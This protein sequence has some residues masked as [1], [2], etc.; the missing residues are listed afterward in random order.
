MTPIFQAT[1]D[2]GKKIDNS[3]ADQKTKEL[4]AHWDAQVMQLGNVALQA[5]DIAAM[6]KDIIL[7]K[8]TSFRVQANGDPLVTEIIAAKLKDVAS[9]ESIEKMAKH[10]SDAL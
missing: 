7:G 4:M 5:S 2:S 1:V 9:N 3:S 8:N 10:F 6:I